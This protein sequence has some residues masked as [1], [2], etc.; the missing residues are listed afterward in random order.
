MIDKGHLINADNGKFLMKLKNNKIKSW[1]INHLEFLRVYVEIRRL[2]VKKS[3]A[4]NKYVIR[5]TYS[6]YLSLQSFTIPGFH[7]SI[8][9]SYKFNEQIVL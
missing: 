1:R 8:D 3:N 2:M 6:V 7:S 5:M 9:V 4:S